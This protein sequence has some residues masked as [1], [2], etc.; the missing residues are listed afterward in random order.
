[1]S[2]LVI[3]GAGPAGLTAAEKACALGMH[4]TII[5]EMPRPGGQIYRQPPKEFRVKNWLPGKSYDKGKDLLKRVSKLKNIQWLCNTVAAGISIINKSGDPSEQRY[6]IHV[7]NEKGLNEIVA[8]AVL[9]APGCYDMAVP[10]PGWTLPG[11]MAAGGIQGFLKNQNIIPGSKFLF[12]GTHPLQLIIADQIYSNGGKIAGIAFSQSI[13][14]MLKRMLKK[15]YAVTNNL[16][17]LLGIAK[18][19]IKFKLLGIPIYFKKIIVNAEGERSLN[20][21]DLASISG[22]GEI[23]FDK[24]TTVNCDCVGLCFGFLASSELPRQLGAQSSWSASRGGWII[25][26]DEWMQSSIKNI[27]VAGE[28]TGV[29]GADMAAVEGEIAALGVAYNFGLLDKDEAQ[30]EAVK[31]RAQLAKQKL[32]ATMLSDISYPGDKLL[33]QLLKPDTTLCRCEGVTVKGFQEALSEHPHIES[34]NA[35]KLL[36]RV[37][38]GFCQGRYCYYHAS[39]IM[40]K[41]R[42]R[43]TENIGAFKSNFPIKPI[44]IA[45]IVASPTKSN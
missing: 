35:A 44:T 20:S 43:S 13:F 42:N 23:D 27:Y 22:N 8:D 38:M 26:H 4:V 9:I 12:S 24:K 21:A 17:Q 40:Q 11:V 31:P 33:L 29:G 18:I 32:F 15:P 30:K 7:S 16:K 37:G 19:I 25:N 2:K 10:F 45:D 6:T 41:M 39:L 28:I 5:N 14:C 1:M 3:I 34:A 36:S